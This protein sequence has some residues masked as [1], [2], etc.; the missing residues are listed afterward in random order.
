MSNKKRNRQGKIA[1]FVGIVTN[2]FLASA[3]ILV[4]LLFSS[5]SVLADGLNNLTDCGSSIISLLS[6]QLSAKPADKEHPYG[7]ERIEYI[8]SSIVSFI[9]LLLAF[10]VGRE[11]VSKIITP[12]EMEFSYLILAV[13][14]GSIAAKIGLFIYYRAVAKKIDSEI[15]K[16]AALDSLGDSVSTVVVLLSLVI[17]KLFDIHIDGYAGLLVSL[18][19]AWS[20]INV[21]KETF[22]KIIGQ[23]PDDTLIFEIKERILRH[24]HVLGIH[25]LNVY[26]YGPNKYFASVHVELDAKTDVLLSHELVDEIEREFAEKTN[27][28][29]T[30]H[31]DPIVTD[32][33]TANAAKAQIERILEEVHEKLS[34]H[35]FRMVKGENTSNLL[36]DISVPFEVKIPFDTL[37]QTVE[38][39]IAAVHPTYRPII[40]IE[41]TLE[42]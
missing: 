20:G 35:D 27:I 29:L 15:L 26:S 18:F 24:D 30:G 42:G 36:F 2:V 39:K 33:E 13:L 1:S 17:G 14:L 40:T 11:S 4:G 34:L 5:V 41:H 3:K 38:E 25:D 23:A 31:L 7:H 28:I 22:S 10:E 16:A 37:R 8:C 9:I 32:D 21:M 19:I 6:F 12:T